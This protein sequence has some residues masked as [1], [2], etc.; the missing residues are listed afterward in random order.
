MRKTGRFVSDNELDTF[1]KS[2]KSIVSLGMS[3]V[4]TFDL[5]PLSVSD[6]Q[7]STMQKS[8][9]AHDI[10]QTQI[11]HSHSTF[12]LL[13]SQEKEDRD[14]VQDIAVSNFPFEKGII[15]DT[16]Q[17]SSLKISPVGKINYSI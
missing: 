2:S 7:V 17:S 3:L 1:R 15:V 12:N 9:H 5:S 13:T 14:E 8:A 11:N 10:Y 4:P 6:E 16:Y